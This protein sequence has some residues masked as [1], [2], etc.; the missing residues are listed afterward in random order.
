MNASTLQTTSSNR[1]A[2]RPH[3]A[4]I[5]SVAIAVLI[6]L[7]FAWLTIGSNDVIT[8]WTFASNA[9]MCGD[10]VYALPGPYGDPF[11]HPPFMIHILKALPLTDLFPFWLRLP[12]IVA[13]IATALI[14]SRLISALS[15]WAL[16]LL[17]LNPISILISGFHG[18]TDSVMVCFIVAA[19][20]AVKK[21]RWWVAGVVFGMSINIKVVPLLLLPGFLVYVRGRGRIA[22]AVAALG[23]VCVASLPY[24][25]HD[26]VTIV[27][28]VLGY[29]G[30]FT[31]SGLAHYANLGG[32][33]I[34][35]L[36]GPL[37]ALIML[38]GVFLPW[39]LRR[40]NTSLYVVCAAIVFAFYFLTPS[41]ALQYLVWG[42]PFVALLSV[43]WMAVFYLTGG[44]LIALQFYRWSN[45][46]W[47]LANSHSVPP[48]T[49]ETEFLRFVLWLSCGAMFY[50]LLN[51]RH[52]EVMPS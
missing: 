7:L 50:F 51:S 20:Y 19:I 42:T 33:A 44:G 16:V 12:S 27:R 11:N 8:W 10:C 25:L 39:Y 43:R 15:P 47:F 3:I 17:A 28:T 13:D 35:I 30:L 46:Q 4:F 14:V 22:F 5:I 23:T 45:G 38:S 31:N 41:L 26:S 49:A 36:A 29:H 37:R 2:S 21:E 9:H 52:H 34:D 6:K 18:N 32:Y 24:L 1:V 40:C 48:A